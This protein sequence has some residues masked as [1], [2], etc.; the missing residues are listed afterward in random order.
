MTQKAP[1]LLVFRDLL[2]EM[3]AFNDKAVDALL[4][5]EAAAH[6]AKCVKEL[7]DW[8]PGDNL[9]FD[10]LTDGLFVMIAG[11]YALQNA[12]MMREAIGDTDAAADLFWKA[13]DCLRKA[14]EAMQKGVEFAAGM[15]RSEAAASRPAQALH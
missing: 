5:E 13:Q 12:V 15:T 14:A 10:E 4:S 7:E 11:A 3:D 2:A 6:F 8:Q 1:E 9:S